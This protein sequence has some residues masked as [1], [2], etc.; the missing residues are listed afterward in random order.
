MWGRQSLPIGEHEVPDARDRF[1]I[2]DGY[3]CDGNLVP[4]LQGLPAPAQF[5]Q[6]G[7]IF[8]LDA[9][10][11]DLASLIGHVKLKNAVGVGPKPR[12]NGPF[13]GNSFCGVVRGAAV[14]RE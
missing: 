3:N 1:A 6:R 4:R 12:H 11:H 8:G 13:Q 10:V 7:W 14:V 2:L 5:D 9:P